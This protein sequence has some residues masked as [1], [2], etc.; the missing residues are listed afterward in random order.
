[1]VIPLSCIAATNRCFRRCFRN[2][3]YLV[4][5]KFY[6]KL[7]IDLPLVPLVSASEYFLIST[8]VTV[9][10]QPKVSSILP[11]W[12]PLRVE[13][14]LTQIGPGSSESAL[15]YSVVTSREVLVMDLIGTR[16]AAVP[17]A[18]TSENSGSSSYL[19]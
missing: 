16:A 19:I 12:I 11:C 1:M 14:T 15:M 18:K 8:G 5:V 9:V 3:F 2:F 17:A 10:F 4:Y 7:S 6:G 13:R